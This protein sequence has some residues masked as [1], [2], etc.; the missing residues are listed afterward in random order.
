VLATRVTHLRATE[1]PP[2][3]RTGR[4]DRGRVTAPEDQTVR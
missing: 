4:F 1:E 3:H 2:E